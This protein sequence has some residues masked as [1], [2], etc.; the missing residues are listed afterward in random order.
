MDPEAARLQRATSVRLRKRRDQARKDFLN[1]RRS[2]DFGY[3]S[4]PVSGVLDDGWDFQSFVQPSSHHDRRSLAVFSDTEL[5]SCRCGPR[6]HHR[7][8]RRT[9]RDPRPAPGV[10]FTD[11]G[12]IDQQEEVPDTRVEP[13]HGYLGP[14]PRQP[15]PARYRS[16][17]ISNQLLSLPVTVS[18]FLHRP[19]A[20]P[21]A[22]SSLWLRRDKM[23]SKWRERFF[24]LTSSH[25]KCFQTEEASVLLWKM[26]V[27]DILDVVM[28]DKKG[29]L[30]LSI[31]FRK[32]G[33][34]MLRSSSGIQAW[35]GLLRDLSGRVSQQQ[36]T[37]EFWSG[38]F[39]LSSPLSS[40][41]NNVDHWLLQRQFLDDQNKKNLKAPSQ[42]LRPTPRQPEEY[43]VPHQ[44]PH[45]SL[46]SLQDGYQHP[47]GQRIPHRSSNRKIRPKSC[48]ELTEN[49]EGKI[50]NKLKV[51]RNLKH[52]D[53]GN[54]SMSGSTPRSA[55]K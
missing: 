11:F 41:R 17:E 33:K 27:S 20:V 21:L 51:T 1:N 13:A 43:Q 3:K 45:Q 36:S 15:G 38:K 24:T 48:I 40:D 8:S 5:D 22:Q 31:T 49:S 53:S 39:P 6:P 35:F 37:A 30:T 47:R 34:I 29:Y 10:K 23:F 2:G 25:L 16:Q 54:S 7:Q 14:A 46:H 28:S 26:S 52:E 9:R 19:E 42:P 18:D 4:S 44:V 55:R 12:F 32:E 50:Y